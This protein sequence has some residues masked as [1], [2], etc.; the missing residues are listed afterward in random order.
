MAFIMLAIIVC[1]LFFTLKNKKERRNRD[2]ERSRRATWH[3][4]VRMHYR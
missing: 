4:S 3:R 2:W 1:A